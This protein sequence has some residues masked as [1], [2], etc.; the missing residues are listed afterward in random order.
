[1]ILSWRAAELAWVRARVR[2]RNRNTSAFRLACLALT[3]FLVP[4]N[5]AL[6]LTCS[7]S[8]LA[9]AASTWVQQWPAQRHL[10]NREQSE[11]RSV[12]AVRIRM[13]FR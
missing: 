3:P 8:T 5:F 10:R 13:P 2:L 11:A 4:E 9:S 7:R 12:P 1:M 6:H